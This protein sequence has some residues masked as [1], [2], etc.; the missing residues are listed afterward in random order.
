MNFRDIRHESIAGTGG[1]PKLKATLG[2]R[3]IN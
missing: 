3:E 1:L 2:S